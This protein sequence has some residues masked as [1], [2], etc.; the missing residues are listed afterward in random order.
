LNAGKPFS[1]LPQTKPVRLINILI[2]CELIDHDYLESE[3][4]SFK[5]DLKKRGKPLKSEEIILKSVLTILKETD[6]KRRK[7]KLQ[8]NK[9]TLIELKND[10]FERQLL[11]SF[12]LIAWLD[13]KLN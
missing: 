13:T 4:R 8:Q 10:P 2:H 6:L 5:R 3:I 12:D 9:E 7:N 11:N 1:Q